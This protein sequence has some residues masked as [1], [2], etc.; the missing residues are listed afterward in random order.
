[1]KANESPNHF[2]VL[3]A[4]GRGMNTADKISTVTRL[5][6]T[7]VELILNDLAVQRLVNRTEKKAS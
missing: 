6:K 5:D 3:D 7:E 1:M 4:I 2:M